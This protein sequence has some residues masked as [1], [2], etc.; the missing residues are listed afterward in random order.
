MPE[1]C[2]LRGRKHD[3][4]VDGDENGEPPKDDQG[5]GHGVVE[6]FYIR[7]HDFLVGFVCGPLGLGPYKQLILIYFSCTCI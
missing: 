2:R 7:A 1:G 3:G 6:E 5:H 4:A